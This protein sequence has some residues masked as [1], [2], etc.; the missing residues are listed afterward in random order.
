MVKSMSRY[1]LRCRECGTVWELRV[2]YSLKDFQ[3]L[4]HYCSVCGKNTF[5]DLV[6]NESA[7]V[8]DIIG[9]R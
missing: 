3:Q 5:H 2:S 9:N 6:R 4:Y 1:L 7:E 8:H